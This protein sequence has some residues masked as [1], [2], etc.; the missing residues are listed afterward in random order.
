[1][2]FRLYSHH[3]R[4]FVCNQ[5]KLDIF[6]L[7]FSNQIIVCIHFVVFP[8]PALCKKKAMVDR[9]LSTTEVISIAILLYE[10]T[11]RSF[12]KVYKYWHVITYGGG[13]L[14]FVSTNHKPL[15]EAP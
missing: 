9:T 13:K 14:V 4:S 7:H 15:S 10:I 8:V 11:T 1:M 3:S 5:G 6:P 2:V 12:S